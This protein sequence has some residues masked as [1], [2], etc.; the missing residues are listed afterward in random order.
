MLEGY[1]Q[2]GWQT[3]KIVRS[4]HQVHCGYVGLNM[5]TFIIRI[6]F[7]IDGVWCR[8]LLFTIIVVTII[9]F[10]SLYAQIQIK[11]WYLE[12]YTIPKRNK[13]LKNT[14][15]FPPMEGKIGSIEHLLV[16]NSPFAR[17]VIHGQGASGLRVTHFIIPKMQ[18][19]VLAMFAHCHL[20]GI[21]LC[22][23]IISMV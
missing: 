12:K 13:K 15:F 5:M 20:L 8:I 23:R 11:C 3:I 17:H 10:L 18:E 21:F 19:R 22:M 14:I 6:P 1:G 16:E 2:E 4:L 9:I 7:Q